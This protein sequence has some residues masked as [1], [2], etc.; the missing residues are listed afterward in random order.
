MKI[1]SIDLYRCPTSGNKLFLKNNYKTFYSDIESGQL[2]VEGTG[3]IYYILNGIAQFL[4]ITEKEKNN[5]ATNLF[6][7]K[8]KNYDAYQHLSFETFYEDETEVRNSLIDKLNLKSNSIVLEVNSGTGRDSVL[9]AKRLSKE[10]NFHVQD[11]SLDMLEICKSKLVNTLVPV[12]IH[13]GN[14]CKLP[15]ADKTFDAVYSFGGVGMNTYAEN[16][17]ALAEL[18]R[19][20]K[21]GGK[22]VFGGL[23]LGPWLNKT[24]FG[25]VLINH[26]EHYSNSIL[27]DDFPIEARNVNVSW[28]LSGAGF[29]VDFIVGEG[30]PIANFEYEIPG[31]RGGTHFTR[32]YGKLEGVTLETKELAILAREKLGISMHQWLNEIIK[33]EAIKVLNNKKNKDA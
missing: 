4:K 10:G 26:N 32:F 28:I 24:R 18:V 2:V 14:A 29:V 17:I 33:N 15:Y 19:V 22:I 27:F 31:S 16:K 9:I 21:V 12:E 1:E 3:E 6:K 20:T 5:Y 23:S 7:E 30:E 11:L 8:A 25:K 13:Q